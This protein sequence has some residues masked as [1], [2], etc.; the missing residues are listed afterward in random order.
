MILIQGA[1]M[2]P[3]YEVIQEL[4][5]ALPNDWQVLYR[6]RR[7]TDQ[8]PVLLKTLRQGALSPGHVELLA[9]EFNLLRELTVEGIPRAVEFLRSAPM[10]GANGAI[11]GGCLV[12]EDGGGEP[13]SELP[14]SGRI[15]LNCFFNL[16]IRLST[17]LAE[18]HRQ[19][20]TH[21]NLN[22]RGILHNPATGEVWLADLSRAVKATDEVQDSLSPHLLHGML[23]YAS[24][25]Q[26]GRMNRATDYRTDFYSLGITFYELLTGHLPFDS[27]DV[28]ELIHW[29]IAKTPAAPAELDPKIPEPLS[30]IVMKLLAK[31]A[32]DRYQ[33]AAGLRADLEVCASEWAAKGRIASSALGALGERDVSDRFLIPRKLYGRDRDVEEL[34]AAFDRTCEGQTTMML[35]AGYSGIGKTS[36][37]QEL[38]KPIIRQRGYFI[39]GKFDQ[40]A[41]GTPFGA[42]IQALR[43]LVRQLLGESEERLAVWRDRLSAA[44]GASGGAL[45]E[46]IPEIELIVGKQQPMPVVGPMEALNRFQ[47]VFRN[48]VGALARPEHPLVVFLDD[49]Q[50]ADAATLGLLQP[51]LASPGIQSLFLM[52]AYRNNEVDAAHL[53][54]RTMEGLESAGVELRR[55][56]LGPLELPDLTRFISDT[57]R[58]GFATADDLEAAPLAGLVWEKTAGNPF[59]VIQFLKAL[60]QEGFLRFDY[61]R[62]RWTYRI[63]EIVGAA[64]T[65][66]V[67]DLMTRKIQRLSARTQRALT[68]ASCIGNSFDQQ[69]LAIVSEQSPETT[70]EV[71]KE[72]IDDRLILPIADHPQSYAFLHDRVQQ[73]AYA[74]IPEEW[75]Q[76]VHL[77]VGRLLRE[78]AER[79]QSEENMFDVVHHLNLGRGLI[80]DD[81]ERLALAQLNLSAGRKARSSTAYNAA[82]DTLKAGA[83]LLKESE[84][85]SDYDLA[86]ALHLEAAECQNLCGNFD[87]AEAAFELLLERA[88]T[89]LDRARVHSLRIVQYEN[90]SRYADAIASAREALSL[91]GVAFPSSEP[92]QQATLER[93]VEEIQSLLGERSIASLLDLPTMTDP[94]IRM[95]MNILTT[96]WSAAY[97]SGN[98]LLTRL[99]SATMVRLSLIHGN[100]EESAYGYATHTITVGPVREDYEAAY[101]FGLLA[102]AVNERFNDS[103]RRAKIYQQFHAHAN[104]WRRPLETCIP[105]A[106]EASRS[107]F[108]TGDFTYGIYGAF[109]ETWVA[110][111]ITQ[112]LAQFI[113][114]Y[115]PNLALFKKLKVASV[116]DGQQALLNWAHALRGETV[117]PTSLSDEEFDED[118]YVETYRDNP[119][120]TICYAVTKLQLY[121]LFGEYGKALA[122][123]RVGRGIVHHLEGTI[124]PVIF[125]FWNGLTL[126]A[127][128]ADAGEEEQKTYL[129]ELKEARRSFAVLAGNCPENYHYQSLLLSAELERITGHDLSALD[130]YERA[131]GYAEE[132]EMIQYQALGNELCARFTLSR[133]R[134]KIAAMFLAEARACYEQWGAAAKV[135]ELNRKHPSLLGQEADRRGRLQAGSRAEGSSVADS[136]ANPAG[137]DTLDHF[138]VMKAA[139]AIAG[140]IE[141][142]KLLTKLMHIAIEN[143]GAERGS[144]ILEH[145]GEPFVHAEGLINA[146]EVRLHDPIPLEEAQRLPAGIVNYVRRTSESIVLADARSDDRYGSDPYIV[147]RQPRSVMCIPVLNQSRLVGVLYLENDQ[148]AGAFTPER[149]LICQMLAAQAAIS[150]ENARLYNEVKSSEETLRSIMEGTAALTGGDFFSSLVRHLA[151]AIPVKIAFVTECVNLERTRAHT[152]AFWDGKGLMEDF[153]Y[154]VRQ[155]TCEKVYA[156]ETCFYASELQK[157]F[158]EETAL[159]DLEGQSYIGIPVRDSAGD[160]IGHLAVID[161][162]P[163]DAPRGMDILKIFAAR[164]GAEL[165]RMKAEAGLRQAMAEIEQLKNQ[166]HAENI[167]LQEEI[168][169]EHNFEEI[170]GSSPALLAVLQQVERVAPTD[171]TVLILG[172][173]GTG[174]ELIARAIHD[175]SH[176]VSRPLVKVNCGAISAGLVESELF[177]HVKGAFTGA[178]AQR[179]GRFEL[180]DGGTLFLDE[181]GELPLETQVKLLRVLQDGEF[182]PVGGSKTIK[183]NVRIIAATNR[184]LEDEVRAGRFRADLFYRLNVL[185][186][187]NPPLRDRRSDIPQLAMFFLS[188]FSRR[189][190]RTVEGIAQGTIDLMMNY[191]WPGNIRELQNLI[192]R[193]VVL[194]NGSALTIDRS[195]LPAT[196]VEQIDLAE[197]AMSENQPS[198]IASAD[199]QPTHPS[200]VAPPLPGP[201]TSLDELQRQHILSVLAQTNWVIEGASGA[202]KMLNLHPNTLRSR[203]K[204]M[205]IQRPKA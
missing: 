21:R 8:K 114:D 142:E 134:K 201:S 35:V 198:V 16:A 30:R 14:I 46:V 149:I 180:A 83:G 54:T 171:A 78:R 140:E 20:I 7:S 34:V 109:T 131:I 188:R 36:L 115:T 141:L 107:G 145:E 51:L 174:K 17:I 62:G 103:R 166:L 153:E 23:A 49:L 91:F 167:Y 45:A 118:E 175:R 12:M 9:H 205:G 29:H 126:A 86:F 185:P 186:L 68:L 42:L 13:L 143:A 122:A 66:N 196:Q 178:L 80:A 150:L 70:A 127:N 4:S 189:F 19:N 151:Q 138:S 129:A 172:E 87:E 50:W 165:G 57:L 121:Y 104:L 194:S 60:K 193:G 187:H 24:P 5:L 177:G 170:V 41:R 190:G 28:L 32:E 147:R 65:D 101:E 200:F 58:G 100:S 22:P 108:E 148:A 2:I 69:T 204:K 146:A 162:Q 191:R 11:G 161:D 90:L 85:E 75:K 203:L 156:G 55:V 6:G 102:L 110:I 96:I 168:R 53:L 93:E 116:G 74:L 95:V 176:R 136:A 105:Y 183:V 61:D 179:T 52:G 160:L 31:T 44:M 88:K 128:Y 59:F 3:N 77:A 26:T 112:N 123:A 184:N 15:E 106:R 159:V 173:T 89:H 47:S 192:E 71:L 84:W 195:L 94:E 10:D 113:R 199:A 25:E 48:F 157:L 152:L 119:F 163:M 43:A 76:L 67:V 139:Q 39:S 197:L 27:S 130:L 18:L 56:D 64:M 72:A 98:Q 125:E 73:A 169:R 132:T 33:S 92:E 79:E 81:A 117:A 82:L 38:Y 181:V 63:D 97:I 1:S 133:G 202:A 120:F 111:V 135:E 99:I 155:T 154:D 137:D 124:W 40:V 37:I 164:A 144:L 158:P 182:E